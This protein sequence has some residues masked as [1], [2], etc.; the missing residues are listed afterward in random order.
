VCLQG[1]YSQ[2]CH[3]DYLKPKSHQK[4]SRS[5][6]FDGLR[7]H[8]DEINEVVTRLTPGTLTVAVV[9]DSMDWFDE[10]K[11]DAVRQ[12]AA[13]NR[14]LAPKGRVL[15]RSA[16]LEPWY[17]KKFEEGGFSAKCVGKRVPGSCI[18]R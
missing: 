1:S 8:T 2:R 14:A 15:L 17:I 7:I 10:G 12:I 13:L 11:D 3:P 6:A 5:G 4:L 18:D 16:G 9:M